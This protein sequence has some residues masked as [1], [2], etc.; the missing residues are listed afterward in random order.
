MTRPLRKLTASPIVADH[1][2]QA[3][4]KSHFT[5][6]ALARVSPGGKS[7]GCVP[8]RRCSTTELI[9]LVSR[10]RYASQRDSGLEHGFQPRPPRFFPSTQASPQDVAG[11]EE[12]GRGVRRGR[13]SGAWQAQQ[14][15]TPVRDCG[16][17]RPGVCSCTP[18]PGDAWRVAKPGP[19]RAIG[20]RLQPPALAVSRLGNGPPR[21]VPGWAST[22][23]ASASGGAV[24]GV[25]GSRPSA[26]HHSSHPSQCQCQSSHDVA[27][28]SG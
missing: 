13:R 1:Q 3:S 6:F 22:T 18:Q 23:Q 8:V 10:A 26:S 14:R 27:G 17:T 5:Q 11:S 15:A 7:N 2:P 19:C 4:G 16:F 24:Q 21:Q 25:P 12:W 28:A 20:S 9:P